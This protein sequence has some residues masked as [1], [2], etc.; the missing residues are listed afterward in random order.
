MKSLSLLVSMVALLLAA[1]CNCNPGACAPGTQSCACLAGG[2]CNAGL[3]CSSDLKCGPA[4]TIGVQVSDATARGCEFVLTEA[5]GTEVVSV[6]F[7][8]GA[9]GSWIRQ[10]PK[11][12]VTVVAGSDAALTGAV[13]LGL[14]GAA[15]GLEF[16]KVSCVDLKGQRLA[17][18]LSIR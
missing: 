2:T 8:N 5:S 16:S 1:G 13:S 9:K 4:V 15:S 18:T 3:V 10:A 12:A 11:V 6:E 14:A 17:S 7:K